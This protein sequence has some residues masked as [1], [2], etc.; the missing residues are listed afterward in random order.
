MTPLGCKPRC[1]PF[2]T[3]GAVFLLLALAGCT[4]ESVLAD[5]PESAS[6]PHD[7][8]TGSSLSYETLTDF[9]LQ[10]G[11][12]FYF[13]ANETD[14]QG[15][16]CVAGTCGRF[17][18]VDPNVALE[19]PDGPRCAGT[20]RESTFAM[21]FEGGGYV[22]YGPNFGYTVS[23]QA[24]GAFDASAF[25][26]LSFWARVGA[27]N[28]APLEIL[29]HDTST[30]PVLPESERKCLPATADF[31]PP[32]GTGCYNGGAARRTLTSEF[33]L[34]TID[35]SELTQ[36]DWGARSPG[37]TA[38]VAEVLRVEFKFPLQAR[39]DVWIDDI[40]WFTR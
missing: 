12:N 24:S 29:L 37:G 23:E 32:L 9:D 10:T 2:T 39:F 18:R 4:G 8:D 5:M 20:P 21:H 38:N 11:A 13:Y 30:Y 3:G 1:S 35:F 25:D 17:P 16:V 22:S 6:E 14:P 34:Y 33:R 28:E 7:C 19:L 26:G 31:I 40:A 27:S 36:G 15:E